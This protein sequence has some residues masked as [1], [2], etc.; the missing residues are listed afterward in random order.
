MTGIR[1]PKRR[2]VRPLANISVDKFKR[3]KGGQ[4]FD[5]DVAVVLGGELGVVWNDPLVA[6]RSPFDDARRVRQ[7]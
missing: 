1:S 3:D 6:D 2:T 7:F 4:G 5:I